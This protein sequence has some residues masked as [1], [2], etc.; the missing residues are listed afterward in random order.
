M[1]FAEQNKIIITLPKIKS[2]FKIVL[3]FIK[4]NKVKVVTVNIL[5]NQLVF[6]L[7]SA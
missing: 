7:K 6:Q 4:Q 1:N 5:T 2:S 3:N